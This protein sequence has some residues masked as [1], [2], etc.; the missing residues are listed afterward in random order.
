MSKARAVVRHL[1]RCD[2][3][4]LRDVFNA[5]GVPRST[6]VVHCYSDGTEECVNYAGVIIHL[7]RECKARYR[8]IGMIE[9]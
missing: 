6:R 7:C 8:K 2:G 9:R 4:E 3:K 5:D 1:P